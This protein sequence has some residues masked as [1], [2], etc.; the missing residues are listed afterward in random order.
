MNRSPSGRKSMQ[1]S[2]VT[3]LVKLLEKTSLTEIS[4]KDEKTELTP[5]FATSI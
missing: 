4:F 1:L 5:G 2:D 3:Q